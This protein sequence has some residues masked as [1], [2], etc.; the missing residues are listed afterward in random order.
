MQDKRRGSMGN[1]LSR[2]PVRPPR[3]PREKVNGMVWPI[4]HAAREVAGSCPNPMHGRRIAT[5]S[6]AVDLVGASPIE[7]IRSG[8]CPSTTS[9]GFASG[10]RIRTIV[11]PLSS[12][13]TKGRSCCP[14][15]LRL[16]HRGDQGGAAST[17]T[18][19]SFWSKYLVDWTRA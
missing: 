10:T 2:S 5:E 11:P 15:Q 9:W 7:W 8:M 12:A 6:P 16:V 3:Q 14:A 13:S 19:V 18:A 17:G 4:P 1:E